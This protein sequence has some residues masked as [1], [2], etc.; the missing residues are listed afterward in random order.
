MSQFDNF[1]ELLDWC[2]DGIYVGVMDIE[3]GVKLELLD[4]W[5]NENKKYEV[6]I[7][8]RL[9]DCWVQAVCDI[10]SKDISGYEEIRAGFA[11]EIKRKRQRG[12]PVR[13]YWRL[14]DHE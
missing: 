3:L 8:R 10:K 7:L 11:I 13:W 14:F 9:Y 4:R 2:E 6:E 5:A 1:G 12:E